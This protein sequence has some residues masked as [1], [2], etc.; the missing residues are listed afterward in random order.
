Q[1]SRPESHTLNA[2]PGPKDT[3]HHNRPDQALLGTARIAMELRPWGEHTL[4]VLDEHPLRGT[5]GALHNGLLDAAQHVR[6]R[7]MLG[8][9]ARLCEGDEGPARTTPGRPRPRS[10]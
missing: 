2:T 3:H 7:A 8:R 5:G 9:L 6:H 10:T 1:Q 4:I